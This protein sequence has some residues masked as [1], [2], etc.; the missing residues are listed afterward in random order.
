MKNLLKFL[1]IIAIVFLFVTTTTAQQTKPVP[2][3][4]AK[5]NTFSLAVD[6]H[7]PGGKSRIETKL[8]EYDGVKS[9]T[10]DLATKIVTIEHDSELIT[11][12]DLVNII[13]RIGHRTEY[14][15][16]DKVITSGCTHGSTQGN[17]ENHEHEHGNE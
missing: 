5:N 10:A 2:P 1:S 4:T 12:Q 7:C 17:T 16:A 11:T 9:V 14:T 15:P 6:F 13:E 8:K 3:A